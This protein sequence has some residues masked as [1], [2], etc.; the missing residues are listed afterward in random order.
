[1]APDTFAIISNTSACLVVVHNS[2]VI[3]IPIPKINEK[4]NASNVDFKVFTE[5]VYF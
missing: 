1:M 5:F 3:S 4:R 2:C